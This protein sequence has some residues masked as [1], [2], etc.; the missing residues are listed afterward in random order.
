MTPGPLAAATMPSTSW[1]R[2]AQRCVTADLF[3]LSVR[4]VDIVQPRRNA[5]AKIGYRAA[6]TV[7][8]D[9]KRPA[10]IKSIQRRF[11]RIYLFHTA[12]LVRSFPKLGPRGS[13]FVHSFRVV[14][15]A[16]LTQKNYSP[17][18]RQTA[19]QNSG[20]NR[21]EYYFCRGFHF[22]RVNLFISGYNDRSDREGRTG[23][24]S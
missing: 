2:A 23:S 18:K 16:E 15:V 14:P 20:D 6:R 4:P 3:A 22:L 7:A 21:T 24:V 1:R 10:V 12:E 11:K 9:G 5:F 19:Q 13:C 17:H 8:L